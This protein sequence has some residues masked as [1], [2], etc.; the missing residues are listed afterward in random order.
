MPNHKYPSVRALL[1]RW[2]TSEGLWQAWLEKRA[3]SPK[4]E[5]DDPEDCELFTGA[6]NARAEAMQDDQRR[7]T[8]Q[9]CATAPLE[10]E[11]AGPGN[12]QV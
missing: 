9:L 1:P 6:G 10:I 7:T 4:E 5:S 11:A 8:D 2:K 3:Y 12:P